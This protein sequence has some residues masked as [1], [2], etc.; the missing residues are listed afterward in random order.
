MEWIVVI[1]L[2][3]VVLFLSLALHRI[4]KK[5]DKVT[6]TIDTIADKATYLSEKEKEFL[7]FAIDMYIE[8]AE[9]LEIHGA[10]KHQI[11]VN[12]LTKI[13]EKNLN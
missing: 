7:V 9:E 6:D 13:K 12:Q 3:V 8:Y 11:I 10:D 5:L 1:I 4:S 2:S